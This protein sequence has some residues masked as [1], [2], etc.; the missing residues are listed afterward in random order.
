MG[1]YSLASK[2]ST[3]ANPEAWFI[4]AFGGQ[5]SSAGVDVSEDSALSISTV[6]AAV[7]IISET[8]ATVPVKVYERMDRGKREARENRIWSVLHDEPNEEQT[9]IEFYE[10]LQGYVELTGSGY[11]Q[12]IR[13]GNGKA[14]EMWPLPTNR[15]KPRRTSAGMLV[16]D[17]RLPIEERDITLPF[18]DVLTVRGFSRDGIKGLNVVDT[19]REPLGLAMALDRFAGSYFGNNAQPAGILSHPS[20]LGPEAK[21]NLKAGWEEMHKG[22]SRANRVA[23]L[24]E[25]IQFTALTIDP[26][27]SQALESRKLSVNEV[28][29]IFNLPPH[30]LKD[31]ERATFSNVEQQ[32]IEFVTVSMRPRFRRFAQALE[33]KFILPSQRN[34]LYIEHVIEELLVGDIKTR[35]EAY[36]VA[37]A[38]GW[39]NANEIRAKENQNPYE[40]GDE[41]HIQLNMVPVRL[42]PDIYEKPE[43]AP[44]GTSDEGEADDDNGSNSTRTA[45]WDALRARQ[46]RAYMHL[47]TD[48]AARCIRAEIGAVR[49]LLKK[50]ND[51][52]DRTGFYA[53]IDSVYEEHE[54]FV[55]RAFMPSVLT[56]TESLGYMIAD[57]RD[58]E[59]TELQAIAGEYV[60]RMA[61]ALVGMSAK[62]LRDSEDVDALLTEWE[63]RAGEIAKRE[64]SAV[65]AAV[66]KYIQE[67]A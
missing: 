65:G 30:I 5:Q 27:K 16:Y 33:K 2:R 22:V 62:E 28:S 57:G 6:F 46:E 59:P 60:R 34:K 50:T 15:V 23:L 55:Q 40:G 42:L 21:K 44:D 45:V 20:K 17:V 56:Y 64:V 63:Q 12:I 43:E 3:L 49:K 67:A 58:V 31:L 18:D 32:A 11:A 10:M 14:V 25:G 7:R 13:D 1:L 36:A 54:R 61:S 47:F 29:R 38:N 8:L 26:Q 66:T 4:R 19:M 51:G 24:D 48:A 52:A 9:P 35:F 39:M 41:Y 53:G 37:K